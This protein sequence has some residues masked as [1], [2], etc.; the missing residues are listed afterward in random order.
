MLTIAARTALRLALFYVAIF[1][2][3]G[4]FLPYWPIW[5]ESRGLSVAEIGVI[6]GASYWPRI[7]TTLMIPLAADRLGERRRTMVWLAATTF[8][9]L[10]LF[11]LVGNFWLFLLLSLLTGGTWAAILP[12]GEA[13]AL[14]QAGRHGLNYGRVRLWGSIAFIS[15]SL[16]GGYVIKLLGTSVIF[17]VILAT[18]AL[19]L[20][21][22]WTMP[23]S[24]RPE[25]R[26]KRPRLRL[27]FRQKGFLQL[28]IASALVQVSHAVFYGFGTLHWRNAGYSEATIGWL[29]AEG[30]I[31]EIVLFMWSARLLGRISN[32]RLIV[33][34]G[35]LAV[36]RWLLNGVSTNLAL[37]ILTQALH[38][39]SFA[40]TYLATIH[41]L[42]DVT[43][44]ELQASAQ[45]FYAAVGLAPLFGL[46]TPLAGWLYGIDSSTAFFAMAGL[47]GAGAALA[48]GLPVSSVR[49]LR[50]R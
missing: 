4:V 14:D 17:P 13:I 18:V 6:I 23:E 26:S 9:G 10:V 42:R 36:L 25:A 43:P 1:A 30:V 21:F 3:V 38:A 49:C 29:W 8:A 34:A 15:M 5:L 47:A 28:V 2:S 20:L 39:A 45:G 46:V 37:L 40:L 44:P 33:V 16:A 7:L 48:F 11:A 12:L 32:E 19:I 27:V 22:C 24:D 41:Y 35:G 31:A 50:P